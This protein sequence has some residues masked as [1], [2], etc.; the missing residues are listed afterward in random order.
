M[1]SHYSLAP[2]RT[3]QCY[4]LFPLAKPNMLQ[5]ARSAVLLEK[6]FLAVLHNH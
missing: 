3:V 2:R 6:E 1:Q 5:P 4:L